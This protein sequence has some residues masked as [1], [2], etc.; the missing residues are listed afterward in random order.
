MSTLNASASTNHG[1][2][3]PPP[4]ILRFSQISNLLKCPVVGICLSLDEQRSLVRKGGVCVA[5]M[6]DFEIHEILVNTCDEN[7]LLSRQAHALL[8]KKY[9]L[10]AAPLRRLDLLSFVKYWDAAFASGR[11][12]AELWAA[13]TRPDLPLTVQHHIFGCVHMDM[14]EALGDKLQYKEH[15]RRTH[16][17]R[18]ALLEKLRTVKAGL[19]QA[20]KEKQGLS[21][22][23]DALQRQKN[24]LLAKNQLL[25]QSIDAMEAASIPACA[26]ATVPACASSVA[27]PCASNGTHAPLYDAGPSVCEADLRARVAFLE[28]NLNEAYS[29]AQTAEQGYAQAVQEREAQYALVREL[30]E[31]VRALL[32]PAQHCASC[33]EPCTACGLCPRRIL[34]VGGMTRLASL[35]RDVVEAKG[36]QFE[37]HDGYLGGVNNLETSLQKADIVLCPVSCNSHRACLLVKNLCKKYKK[38]VHMMPNY[39]LS[40]VARVLARNETSTAPQ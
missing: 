29:R 13:A 7:T 24:A 11:Y 25:Q 28:H 37:Y 38:T 19:T 14:H 40:A 34:M 16:Q 23:H 36:H 20:H 2:A 12:V 6:Q 32:A 27:A 15:L 3:T 18:D 5:K 1:R 17:E 4:S 26:S 31:E 30:Q 39:S 8:R 9:E 21:R 22:Q 10:K 33:T 35:Y